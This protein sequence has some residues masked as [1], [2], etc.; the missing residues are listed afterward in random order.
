MW[1]TATKKVTL[2]AEAFSYFDWEWLDDDH[3]AHE[4][5]SK[6]SPRVAVYEFSSRKETTIETYAGA[7]LVSV[8]DFECPTPLADPPEYVPM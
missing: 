6:T 2:L 5:G 4:T 1:E 7:G 8:P 3:L